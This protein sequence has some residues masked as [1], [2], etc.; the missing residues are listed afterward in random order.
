[1]ASNVAEQLRHGTPQ[2]RSDALAAL[3]AAPPG[4]LHED[5]VLIALSELRVLDVEE[6]S[7]EML[8][9][10]NLLLGRLSLET[11]DDPA[12]RVMAAA[13]GGGRYAAFCDVRR[14]TFPCVGPGFP[15]RV[16]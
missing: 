4:T 3:E 7:R 16:C 2:A 9:R 1:M 11:A 14:V 10:V 12:H 8:E 15:S 6:V 13:W 5:E